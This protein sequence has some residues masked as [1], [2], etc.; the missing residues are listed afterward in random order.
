MSKI[1]GNRRLLK[2]FVVLMFMVTFKVMAQ[3][4]VTIDGETCYVYPSVIQGASNIEIDEEWKND[5]YN[6]EIPPVTQQLKDGKYV[7][8][9]ENMEFDRITS[10]TS[11]QKGVY[12]VFNVRNN[13]KEGEAKVYDVYDSSRTI[14]ILNYKNDLLDGIFQIVIVGAGIER[15][16]DFLGEVPIDLFVD[17]QIIYDCFEYTGSSVFTMKHYLG[18]YQN[19]MLDGEMVV[20]GLLMNDSFVDCIK[21]F[22]QGLLQ[23]DFL[24]NYYSLKS[25]KC[26]FKHAV[27]GSYL[28]NSKHGLWMGMNSDMQLIEKRVYEFG[29]CSH[30][31]S[32]NKR[33]FSVGVGRDTVLKYFPNYK[34]SHLMS[35]NFQIYWQ[36]QVLTYYDKGEKKRGFIIDG[37]ANKEFWF[38]IKRMNT[39]DSMIGDLHIRIRSLDSGI[40]INDS[41]CDYTLKSI[42]DTSMASNSIENDLN[43]ESFYVLTRKGLKNEKLFVNSLN[44]GFVSRVN[45][46]YLQLK[47]IQS[48][49]NKFFKI[50]HLLYNKKIFHNYE[51]KSKKTALKSVQ[52]ELIHAEESEYLLRKIVFIDKQDTLCLVDTLMRDDYSYFDEDLY[53]KAT[54]LEF[55]QDE[56]EKNEEFTYLKYIQQFYEVVRV[57]HNSIQLNNRAYNGNLRLNISYSDDLHKCTIG[58]NKKSKRYRQKTDSIEYRIQLVFPKETIDYTTKQN[59][60]YL[61]PAGSIYLNAI[62]GRI[63]SIQRMDVQ[64]GHY[65]KVSYLQNQLN[66][67]VKN[68][69]LNFCRDGMGY[70]NLYEIPDI[71]KE[72]DPVSINNRIQYKHGKKQG[73]SNFGNRLF[74]AFKNDTLHG[75]QYG[76]TGN[77]ITY[78]MNYQM[79]VLH[80]KSEFKS[81]HGSIFKVPIKNGM[82]D[83]LFEVYRTDEESNVNLVKTIPFKNEMMHDT[84]KI[85]EKDNILVSENLHGNIQFY[86]EYTIKAMDVYILSYI[87]YTDLLYDNM[88]LKYFPKII[89]DMRYA[90]VFHFTPIQDN[91]KINDYYYKGTLFRTGKKGISHI[92]DKYSEVREVGIWYYYREDGKS[93]YKAINYNDSIKWNEEEYLTVPTVQA[94]Y[95]NSKL[96]YKGYIAKEITQYNCDNG[97]NIPVDEINYTEFYDSF[98]NAIPIQDSGYVVEYQINGNVLR[99]GMLVNGYKQGI[100]IE[101]SML[102]VPSQ[103]GMFEGGAKNG[104]WLV[105]EFQNIKLLENVCFMSDEQFEKWMSEYGNTMSFSEEFYSNGILVEER[106]YYLKNE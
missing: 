20:K 58:N 98:G 44:N 40:Y 95:P 5:F 105:G 28:Q 39:N 27:K 104:R 72:Q 49:E 57:R 41:Y 16:S 34:D 81:E 53:L 73:Q 67:E 21:N 86:P 9:F 35:F 15:E 64:K 23:G 71:G 77:A 85:Y 37:H 4:T 17:G 43:K 91:C 51:F 76:G 82:V 26:I 90:M 56:L 11:S 61:L 2:C 102:G 80:G 65:F 31:S 99:E 94:Y 83:G 87:T 1:K 70:N 7:L 79:G 13:K 38:G 6:L 101:Y 103:I 18:N 50:S 25:G 63:H 59:I 62:L 100:W 66:S 46:A 48:R 30:I 22:Q 33:P 12:A 55:K 88:V 74:L 47:A 10:K 97:A 42:V 89:D 54:M 69:N 29:N 84:I 36:D 14:A 32:N 8:Y 93:L 60:F 78:E 75:T 24:K 96:M 19:G 106:Y 45:A 3:E 92:N 68:V 52:H